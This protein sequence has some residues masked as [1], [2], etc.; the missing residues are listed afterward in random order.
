MEEPFVY[1]KYLY[2]NGVNELTSY[3]KKIKNEVKEMEQC[4]KWEKEVAKGFIRLHVWE[5]RKR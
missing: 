4:P 5:Y 1:A 3:S 2:K